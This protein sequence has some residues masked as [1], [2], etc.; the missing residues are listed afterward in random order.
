M[1]TFVNLGILSLNQRLNEIDLI[2]N[3]A[4][5]VF[6]S[7]NSLYNSLCRSAQVLLSAH[8]EGYLK[9]LIKNVMED[10]NQCSSFR[11]SHKQL[12]KRVCEYFLVSNNEKITNEKHIKIQ[13]LIEIFEELNIKFKKEYFYG[14][15]E[16]KNPKAS[17]LDK[18]AEQFGVN[19]FFNQIAQSNLD[20][21]FSDTYQSS[22]QRCSQIKSYLIEKTTGY[23]YQI[24]KEF[25]EIDSEKRVTDNLW[26]A[27]LS[28]ML[29]RRHDIAHGTEIES[30][31]SH[32]TI[33]FDRVKVEIL[34]Y[35]FTILICIQCNPIAEMT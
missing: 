31:V 23:P 13:E 12:K 20:L 18:I 15:T 26:E 16:N 2:V 14:G 1:S 19:V 7:D 30:S 28:D 11:H 21:V 6:E 32:H 4:K 25:L 8:F 17:I 27:F 24:K 33:E 5:G 29:K 22:V 34:L 35:A 3:A 10:I 9:E